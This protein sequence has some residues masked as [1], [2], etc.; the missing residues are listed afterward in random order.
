MFGAFDGPYDDR[1]YYR[2]MKKDGRTYTRADVMTDVDA[3]YKKWR[4]GGT[5]QEDNKKRE[6]ELDKRG[7]NL[8]GSY[9]NVWTGIFREQ[10]GMSERLKNADITVNEAIQKLA[11]IEVSALVV[12]SGKNDDTVYDRFFRRNMEVQL[13]KFNQSLLRDAIIEKIKGMNPIPKSVLE[14]AIKNGQVKII[15]ACLR[16]RSRLEGEVDI[17]A[18]M[19]SVEENANGLFPVGNR[20]SNR[21]VK[22]NLDIDLEI[23]FRKRVENQEWIKGDVQEAERRVLPLLAA[24]AMRHMFNP[25]LSHSFRHMQ[26]FRDMTAAE[27][28]AYLSKPHIFPGGAYYVTQAVEKGLISRDMPIDLVLPYFNVRVKS[29]GEVS[30]VVKRHVSFMGRRYNDVQTILDSFNGFSVRLREM[31]E[32]GRPIVKKEL[33][34]IAEAVVPVAHEVLTA[35]GK[36]VAPVAKYTAETLVMLLDQAILAIIDLL[37]QQMREMEKKAQITEQAVATGRSAPVEPA[38]S[39]PES[40]IEAVVQAVQQPVDVATERAPV[41]PAPSASKSGIEA[42][43]RAVQP[44]VAAATIHRSSTS[45]MVQKDVE[46]SVSISKEVDIARKVKLLGQKVLENIAKSE[47]R[48]M[49][50]SLKAKQEMLACGLIDQDLFDKL[51]RFGDINKQEHRL[52]GKIV[53]QCALA[54]INR[55]VIQRGSSIDGRGDGGR[56][57]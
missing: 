4:V 38:P 18:L 42:V 34:M 32:S 10:Y 51:K 56:G 21:A 1:M 57:R 24:S 54:S 25:S 55:E 44:S 30:E 35:T 31:I 2:E 26:F 28:R 41:E 7:K 46:T 40:V 13:F 37:I 27:V 5:S 3:Y 20:R 50:L 9:K 22:D 45:L 48:D 53:R 14:D 19:S 39:A 15:E 12:N 49:N 36:A 29:V 47:G 52:I 23:L 16:E 11:E 33:K 8:F 43:V 17:M 6:A